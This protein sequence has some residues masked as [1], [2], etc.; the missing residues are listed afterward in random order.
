MTEWLVNSKLEESGHGLIWDAALPCHK[1]PHLLFSCYQIAYVTYQATSPT[2]S[3]NVCHSRYLVSASYLQSLCR[4]HWSITHFHMIHTLNAIPKRNIIVIS[5]S[6][7]PMHLLKTGKLLMW[8]VWNKRFCFTQKTR[9]RRVNWGKAGLNWC[10]LGNIS[11]KIAGMTFTNRVTQVL[12]QDWIL[13]TFSFMGCILRN[14]PH[15]YS[16]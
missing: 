1:R 11:K 9:R 8:K 10:W 7:F 12:K 2:C 16:V 4:Y 6:C 14:C 5:H 13:W 15:S 3:H